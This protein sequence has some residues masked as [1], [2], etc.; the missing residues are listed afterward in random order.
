MASTLPKLPIFEAIA[1]HDRQRIAII[2]SQSQKSYTY[3]Q[4]LSDISKSKERLIEGAEGNGIEGQR[5]SFLVENSYDY[6]GARIS[7]AENFQG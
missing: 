1:S 5:I 7:V 6:V 2:H 4:L 3:G